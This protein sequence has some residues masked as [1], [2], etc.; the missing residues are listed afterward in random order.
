VSKVIQVLRVLRE[1]QDFKVLPENK[2]RL[3]S[4][5]H[6]ASPACKDLLENKELLVNR[7]Q[8]V[9]KAPPDFRV[10]LVIKV[11]RASKV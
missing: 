5:V 9:S 1:P 6:K 4:K 3:V 2:A 7:A 10:R 8:R 11:L